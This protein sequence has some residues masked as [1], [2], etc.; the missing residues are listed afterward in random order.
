MSI[1]I[2]MYVQCDVCGNEL[3][4]KYPARA[5]GKTFE[6][7]DAEIIGDIT[8]STLDQL[9]ERAWHFDPNSTRT[10]AWGH[11]I[12]VRCHDCRHARRWE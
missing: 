4:D 10:D 2:E 12:T 11:R 9:K 3:E 5:T 6:D 8:A 7:F 1:I